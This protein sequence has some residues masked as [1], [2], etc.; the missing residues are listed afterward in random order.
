MVCYSTCGQ[1]HTVSTLKCTRPRDEID[2]FLPEPPSAAR[3]ASSPAL[4]TRAAEELSGRIHQCPL[5]TTTARMTSLPQLGAASTAAP[6]ASP[7]PSRPQPIRLIFLDID[8]VICC[9]NYGRLEPQKLERLQR[10]VAATDARVVLSS[11]WRRVPQAK[12]EALD[13]L[14]SYGIR[15]IG[16]TPCRPQLL[17]V[18]PQEI[19]A[20]MQKY[21]AAPAYGL[22]KPA[23]GGW[24]AIDDRWL[25]E[26]YGGAELI[27]HFVQ[28]HIASGLTDNLA[29]QAIQLLLSQDGPPAGNA[30]RAPVAAPPAAAE[31][32]PASTPAA[33]SPLG[34]PPVGAESILATP[35]ATAKSVAPQAAA[36]GYALGRLDGNGGR[37]GAAQLTELRRTGPAAQERKGSPTESAAVMRTPPSADRRR[38]L[39]ALSIGS[40]AADLSSP[41]PA[42]ARAQQRRSS[43]PATPSPSLAATAAAAPGAGGGPSRLARRPRQ[44]GQYATPPARRMP[45]VVPAVS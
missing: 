9:N 25:T 22:S 38:S 16:T 43:H 29:S 39:A 41:Q 7:E 36:R 26:E 42:G 31:P 30:A 28:T 10:I 21:K 23:I 17:P 14:R 27:G 45:P 12:R 11:D 1:S 2:I 37:A 44:A 15:V 24:I 19:L 34:M 20:W 18:R 40:P 4:R 35:T 3:G 13:T 32:S 8:G 33:S 5:A 6:A